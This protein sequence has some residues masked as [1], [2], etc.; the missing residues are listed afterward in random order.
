MGFLTKLEENKEWNARFLRAFDYLCKEKFLKQFEL[1]KLMGT[2][3]SLISAYRNGTK[4]ASEDIMQRLGQ[5]WGG[6]LYMPYLTGESDYMLIESMSDKVFNEEQQKVNNPDYMVKHEQEIPAWAD[7]FISI[8]SKQV[9]E[10]EALNR[11]LKAE[12]AEV[13]T[14]RA[15]LQQAITAFRII[16]HGKVAPYSPFIP[17]YQQAAEPNE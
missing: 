2:N 16:Q 15:E 17:E 9:V 13:R 12:L 11:Q 4:R 10:N 14:L 8:L 6:R 5:A 1:A 3:S 7:T